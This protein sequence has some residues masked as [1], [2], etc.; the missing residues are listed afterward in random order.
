MRRDIKALKKNNSK[1]KTMATSDIDVKN[2]TEP[3]NVSSINKSNVSTNCYSV[4]R[5]Q[6]FRINS[7]HTKYFN[8]LN[9]TGNWMRKNELDK[10]KFTSLSSKDWKIF[11]VRESQRNKNTPRRLRN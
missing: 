7:A 6:K 1:T 10:S 5:R 8:R 3:M 2:S 11:S 9:S 4:K